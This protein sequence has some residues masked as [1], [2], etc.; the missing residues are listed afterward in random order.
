MDISKNVAFKISLGL[1][2]RKIG[3]EPRSFNTTSYYNRLNTVGHTEIH[4]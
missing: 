3:L 1:V 2:I 4:A